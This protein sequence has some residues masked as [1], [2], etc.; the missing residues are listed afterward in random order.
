M[1]IQ[2]AQEMKDASF[3]V[4][5]CIYNDTPAMVPTISKHIGHTGPRSQLSYV[6][7]KVARNPSAPGVLD[8][9]VGYVSHHSAPCSDTSAGSRNKQW[10]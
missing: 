6:N 3:A 8:L 2:A 9:T 7:V 4:L 1:C 5:G 10:E